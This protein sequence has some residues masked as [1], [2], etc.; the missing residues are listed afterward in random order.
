[1]VGERYIYTNEWKGDFSNYDEWQHR[2][3]PLQLWRFFS[4][5]TLDAH[6]IS[7]L[8]T[9]PVCIRRPILTYSVSLS[10]SFIYAVTTIWFYKRLKWNKK[11]SFHVNFLHSVATDFTFSV[12][13]SVL[14]VFSIPLSFLVRTVV[15]FRENAQYF[16]FFPSS[17]LPRISFPSSSSSS[18]S[19][20]SSFSPPTIPTAFLGCP[21][22]LCW[23][24]EVSLLLILIGVEMKSRKHRWDRFNQLLLFLPLFRVSVWTTSIFVFFLSPFSLHIRPPPPSKLSHFT[25]FPSLPP[26]STPPC[27]ALFIL[28][29]SHHRLSLTPPPPRWLLLWRRRWF[30]WHCRALA[31][32]SCCADSRRTSALVREIPARGAD[33]AANRWRLKWETGIHWQWRHFI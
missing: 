10:D 19:L 22:Y 13:H 15:N 2:V 8:K 27:K 28:T 6:H 25:P 14:C 31:N 9:I 1:M 20:P 30:C 3:I 24:L 33:T 18:P 16:L 26:L 29:H 7:R 32:C 5:L 21:S 4:T 12:T 17:F 11:C 23:N